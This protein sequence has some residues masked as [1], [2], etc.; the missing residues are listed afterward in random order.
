[1]DPWVLEEHLFF[2]VRIFSSFLSSKAS[3][4][5]PTRGVGHIEEEETYSFSEAMF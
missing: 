2:Q 3:P 1:M 5:H 4:L